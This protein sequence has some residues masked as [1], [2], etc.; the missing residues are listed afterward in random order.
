MMMMLIWINLIYLRKNVKM[1]LPNVKFRILLIQK[2]GGMDVSQKTVNM[3]SI[4][5]DSLTCRFAN[6]VFLLQ[7]SN[8]KIID[9]RKNY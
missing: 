7:K 6:Y 5:T 4:Q 1:D 9:Y 8:G 3:W 2:I